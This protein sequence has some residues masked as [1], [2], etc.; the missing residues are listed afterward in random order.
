MT[1]CSCESSTSLAR[2]E[3]FKKATFDFYVKRQLTF[4]YP[5]N[6]FER[7]TCIEDIVID[8]HIKNLTIIEQIGESIVLQSFLEQYAITHPKFS[9]ET[10]SLNNIQTK[11]FRE[12]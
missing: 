5:K 7:A 6:A 2:V 9:I 8:K 4:R 3:C 1:V 10:Q 12:I 11:L